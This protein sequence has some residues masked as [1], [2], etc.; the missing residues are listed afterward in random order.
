[1]LHVSTKASQVRS[2]KRVA[3][4]HSYEDILIFKK[5]ILKKNKNKHS[6]INC[7]VLNATLDIKQSQTKKKNGRQLKK[8]K[9]ILRISHSSS[10]HTLIFKK[11]LP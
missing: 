3:A 4:G 2:L 10:T 6:R 1:M 11:T 7:G 8:I 9:K 5:N